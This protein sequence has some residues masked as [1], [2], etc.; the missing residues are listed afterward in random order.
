MCCGESVF[1]SL[2]L[3]CCPPTDLSCLLCYVVLS[4]WFERTSFVSSCRLLWGQGKYSHLYFNTMPL[5][6]WNVGLLLVKGAYGPSCCFAGS[7]VGSC[8]HELLQ[9]DAVIHQGVR[10]RRWPTV[11]G[12]V[13]TF[14]PKKHVYFPSAF[15]LVQHAVLTVTRLLAMF[16]LHLPH[17]LLFIWR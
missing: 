16:H 15:R 10:C 4:Y 8:V 14:P 7:L 11:S 6:V 13:R 12:A 9:P 1:C 17:W 3:N 5:C 2:F